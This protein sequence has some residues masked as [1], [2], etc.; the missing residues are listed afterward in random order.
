MSQSLTIN[1][2]GKIPDSTTVKA[3]RPAQVPERKR[4][5]I[6]AAVAEAETSSGSLTLAGLPDNEQFILAYEAE[7]KWFYPE[8]IST[9][10]ISRDGFAEVAS[11]ESVTLPGAALVK[12]T[13]STEV[14]KITAAAAGTK[15]TLLIA[16]TAK[17]VDGE[18]LKLSAAGPNTADDT[19]SLICDGTNW[20]ETGRAVN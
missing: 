6:G 7:S 4:G 2:A 9:Q 12:V 1:T 10:K 8:Y 3:F 5:P 17:L 16:A 14:K 11:A 15:V 19:I 13:G 20:Y 18:N